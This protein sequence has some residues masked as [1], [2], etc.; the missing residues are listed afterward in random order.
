M[1]QTYKSCLQLMVTHAIPDNCDAVWQCCWW[2]S[3][4]CAACDEK[5]YLCLYNK[6]HAS[7][8]GAVFLGFSLFLSDS[9][10]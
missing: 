8:T 2:I 3:I 5:D 4:M 1:L 6:G 9:Q 10:S 7:H